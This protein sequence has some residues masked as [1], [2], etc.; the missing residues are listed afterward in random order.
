MQHSR[1]QLAH[2]TG[3][4]VALGGMALAGCAKSSRSPS[5]ATVLRPSIQSSSDTLDPSNYS[6]EPVTVA[7]ITAGGVSCSSI[8][9]TP[10]GHTD[11]WSPQY[12]SVISVHDSAQTYSGCASAT[13][14]WVDVYGEDGGQSKKIGSLTASYY[15][16]MWVNKN[17]V[18]GDLHLVATVNGTIDNGNCEFSGW[19]IGTGSSRHAVYTDTVTV[20]PFTSGSNYIEGDFTCPGGTGGGGKGQFGPSS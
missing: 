2:V 20:Q 11:L 18:D 15:H 14:G 19:E 3:V 8:G 10:V 16:Q 4:I 12:N 13:G 7:A 9:R 5:Q 1:I 6:G 17:P